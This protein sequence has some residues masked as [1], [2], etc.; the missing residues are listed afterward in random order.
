VDETLEIVG[1]T[2]FLSGASSSVSPI[3]AEDLTTKDYVDT[4]TAINTYTTTET[5]L[6][7]SVIDD[8]VGSNTMNDRN[9]K[10]F[11]IITEFGT[12]NEKVYLVEYIEELDKYGIEI[13]T[14]L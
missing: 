6:T 8:V 14:L 2:E 7:R 10:L 12:G 5:T 11:R 1:K 13:L 4:T 9:Q 3:E